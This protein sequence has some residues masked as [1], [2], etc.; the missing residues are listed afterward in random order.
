MGEEVIIC[1]KTVFSAN[2]QKDFHFHRQI[3]LFGFKK[4]EVLF[5]P[6]KTGRYEF[7]SAQKYE[8]FDGEKS[9]GKKAAYLVKGTVYTIKIDVEDAKDYTF[10]VYEPVVEVGKNSIEI[11]DKEAYEY[12]DGDETKK[13]LNASEYFFT[14]DKDGKY[15]ITIDKDEFGLEL[16]DVATGEKYAVEDDNGVIVIDLKKD[17]EYAVRI[18]GSDTNKLVVETAFEIKIQ[19]YEL[20][21]TYNQVI[22]PTDSK[23]EVYTFVTGATKLYS[24]KLYDGTVI[25]STD[26]DERKEPEGVTIV[27]IDEDGKETKGEDLSYVILEKGKTYQIKVTREVTVKSDVTIAI[28]KIQPTVEDVTVTAK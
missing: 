25:S 18:V 19:S 6:E 20:G 11:S 14:P 17:K 24:I 16:I 23:E 13:G 12:K 28:T 21:L 15:V 9:L 26:E 3:Q 8:I 1:Q 22:L 2:L 10:T 27:L 4:V 7:A 5:N